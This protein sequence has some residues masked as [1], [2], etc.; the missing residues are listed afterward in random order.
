[1]VHGRRR[2]REGPSRSSEEPK[3][4]ECIGNVTWDAKRAEDPKGL[5]EPLLLSDIKIA[6][7][8]TT[9]ILSKPTLYKMRKIFYVIANWVWVNMAHILR[10]SFCSM[11]H[12]ASHRFNLLTPF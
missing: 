9:H 7:F 3:H 5:G 2:I 1:L 6:S 12:S 4:N 11:S 10:H 8:L